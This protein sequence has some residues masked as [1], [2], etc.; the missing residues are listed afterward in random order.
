MILMI[1]VP[2]RID[3]LR[4][5][6]KK[7][8]ANFYGS[9]RAKL[10]VSGTVALELP[11]WKVTSKLELKPILQNVRQ[12]CG[13]VRVTNL[14]ITIHNS[15]MG[16]KSLFNNTADLTGMFD[17]AEGIYVSDVIQK[18]VFEITEDGDEP[19]RDESEDPASGKQ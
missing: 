4:E 17:K 12:T 15:Q 3:G 2:N 6:L 13:W 8:D 11:K 14:I 7:L 16:V 19:P 10:R 1:I 5:L 18:T 9:I